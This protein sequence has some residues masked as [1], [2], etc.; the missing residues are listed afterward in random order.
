MFTGNLEA[1]SPCDLAGTC[2]PQADAASG[3]AKREIK[4]NR[5]G[6]LVILFG[7]GGEPLPLM[8]G[9]PSIIYLVPQPDRP[10]GDIIREGGE[11]E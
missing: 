8:K 6:L 1:R 4:I 3:S 11:P 2:E 7:R 5:I 9:Q 10:T